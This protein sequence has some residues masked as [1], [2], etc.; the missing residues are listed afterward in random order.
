MAKEI[1]DIE[2]DPTTV[3][4]IVNDLENTNQSFSSR[5]PRLKRH[6]SD[7]QTSLQESSELP[8]DTDNS[9]DMEGSKG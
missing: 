6:S 7:V 1:L 2:L 3:R 9:E 8:G 4:R 5:P